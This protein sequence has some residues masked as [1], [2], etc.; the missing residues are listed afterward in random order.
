MSV[1]RVMFLSIVLIVLL[2]LGMVAIVVLLRNLDKFKPT[3]TSSSAD[4]SVEQ[5]K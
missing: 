3:K 5:K 4:K 1:E 2:I